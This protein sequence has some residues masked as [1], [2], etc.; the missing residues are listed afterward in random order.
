M[1]FPG[2]DNNISYNSYYFKDL[3]FNLILAHSF[4]SKVSRVH[5]Q[6]IT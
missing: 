5:A 2:V 4:G 3:S 1:N 6:I